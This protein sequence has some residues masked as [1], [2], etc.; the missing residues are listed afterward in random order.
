MTGHGLLS[1]ADEVRARRWR[2]NTSEN[3]NQTHDIDKR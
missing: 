3:L 2:E 1:V